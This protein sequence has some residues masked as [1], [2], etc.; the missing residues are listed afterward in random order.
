MCIKFWVFQT[1]IDKHFI[2]IYSNTEC[3]L[4]TLLLRIDPAKYQVLEMMLSS[5]SQAY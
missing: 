5:S 3:I 4:Y 1:E 2:A